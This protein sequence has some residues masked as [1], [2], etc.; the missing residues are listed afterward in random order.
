MSATNPASI[1]DIQ[2]VVRDFILEN[3]LFSDNPSDLRND[4]S[5]LDEG[6]LDST[7]ILEVVMFLEEQFSTVISD[8]EMTPENLDSVDGMVSFLKKKLSFNDH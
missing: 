2:H 5:L 3:Y 6:I 1:T 8:D 7:G 4:V